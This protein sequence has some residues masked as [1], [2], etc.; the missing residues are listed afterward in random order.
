MAAKKK[1]VKKPELETFTTRVPVGTVQRLKIAA[2]HHKVS[3]QELVAIGVLRVL[4]DY[5]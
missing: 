2:A 4:G 3:V 5:P 1:R